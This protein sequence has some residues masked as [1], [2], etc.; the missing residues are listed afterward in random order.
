[1]CVCVCVCV[2]VYVCAYVLSLLPFTFYL[3]TTS[4]LLKCC[5]LYACYDVNKS[6][7]I[8]ALHIFYY[9][10]YGDVTY[11]VTIWRRYPRYYDVPNPATMTSLPPLL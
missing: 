7:A 3:F 9:T 8:S 5:Y 11:P 2:C 6:S 10:L 4:T 1:M